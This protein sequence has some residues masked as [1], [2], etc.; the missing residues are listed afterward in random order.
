MKWLHCLV[1]VYS[2]SHQPQPLPNSNRVKQESSPSLLHHRPTST[3]GL[4]PRLQGYL[5]AVPDPIRRQLLHCTSGELNIGEGLL[6]I[7][8]LLTNELLQ[9]GLLILRPQLGTAGSLLD[10]RR[11]EN[12]GGGHVESR[13]RGAGSHW[14]LLNR[15]SIVA[16]AITTGL[17]NGGGS[18]EKW[19]G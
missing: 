6:G 19:I 5:A 13:S 15:L 10:D 11:R 3:E 8:Q 16:V 9:E 18:L 17:C 2:T 7:G 14:P 1:A 4:D 12:S